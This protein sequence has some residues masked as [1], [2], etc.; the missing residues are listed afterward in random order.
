MSERG[1]K[2]LSCTQHKPILKNKMNYLQGIEKKE[3]SIELRG[4]LHTEEVFKGLFDFSI[5][6][7]APSD[8]I[9]LQSRKRMKIEV[10]DENCLA[11]S[12]GAPN[13]ELQYG[14]ALPPPSVVSRSI[15]IVTQ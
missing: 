14:F 15:V 7:K 5:A 13:Q 4:S 12:V 8:E 2:K 11:D 6:F 3:G 10:R 9:L 1:R